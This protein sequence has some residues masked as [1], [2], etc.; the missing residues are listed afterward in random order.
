MRYELP[1]AAGL[2]ELSQDAT[3]ELR[4]A[5]SAG[6]EYVAEGVAGNPSSAALRRLPA[7]YPAAVADTG[8]RFAGEA[9]PAFGDANRERALAAL[10]AAHAGDPVWRAWRVAYAKARPHTRGAA[11]PYQA[12][13]ALEA[14]LRTARAYDEHAG[15]PDTS[16]ALARWAASGESGYCQMFAATLAALARLSGVPARVAE[17]FAPGDRRDGVYRVTD[18]DAHAW[19]EAW[20][21][22]HGW[23]P[24]D[25]TP[26][27]ALPERA[28]SSS[29]AFDGQAAQARTPVSGADGKP[30]AA[31]VAARRAARDE[32][33]RPADWLRE[34]VGA[35]PRGAGRSTARR[36]PRGRCCSPSARCCAACSRA[37]QPAR[38]AGACAR[39]LPIRASISIPRSRRASS[40]LRSSTALA[41]RPRRSREHSSA[42]PTRPPGHATKPLSRARPRG[43]CGRCGARSG[44]PGA[45]AG[46]SRREASAPREIAR[47]DDA[48]DLGRAVDDLQHLGVREEARAAGTRAASRRRPSTSLQAIAAAQRRVGAEALGVGRG[49]AALGPRRA[50]AAAWR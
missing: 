12:V 39:S 35:R 23:L 14:W 10:F 37:T 9:I 25:A 36:P 6:L 38:R 50:R 1:P 28:S 17:G 20:F 47:D 40:A 29:H 15:L 31:A 49:D 11:T 33:A 19:V 46:R 34:R 5:P 21:P 2:V 42:R 18:R 7:D 43:C 8:L 30:A 16:D 3:A 32:R 27:R 48:L 41:F 24:F 13:V 4:S 45:C 44:A 22:G 26:G